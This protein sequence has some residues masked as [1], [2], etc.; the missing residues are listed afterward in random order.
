MDDPLG[1]AAGN[2]LEVA[3]SIESLQNEGPEDLH[4][5]AMILGILYNKK[6]LVIFS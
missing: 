5:L 3:E 4:Q 1:K 6:I 2:A